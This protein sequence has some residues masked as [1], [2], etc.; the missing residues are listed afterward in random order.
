MANIR[1]KV[2]M[3]WE[4]SRTAAKSHARNWPVQV[5][6]G[7]EFFLLFLFRGRFDGLVLV[8]VLV[9]GRALHLFH[10]ARDQAAVLNRAGTA[11]HEDRQADGRR[12][13][14]QAN[15]HG[16]FAAGPGTFIR[17][18]RGRSAARRRS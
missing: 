10:R 11:Q 4:F 12:Q 16:G 6:G 7:R 14:S 2:F 1:L 17:R 3:G 18:G 13:N 9:F 5:I 8:F 15:E